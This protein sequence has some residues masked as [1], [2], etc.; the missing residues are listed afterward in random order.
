M[1]EEKVM[2]NRVRRVAH[3][4]GYKVIKSRRRDPKAIDYGG[5]MLIDARKNTVILGG[6]PIAYSATIEEIES[7]LASE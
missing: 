4:R 7:Y 1:T 3:R 6:S 2:E 5:F